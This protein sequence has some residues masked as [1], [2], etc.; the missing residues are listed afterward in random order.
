MKTATA[1]EQGYYRAMADVMN[2]ANTVDTAYLSAEQV[3]KAFHTFAD[4]A[5]PTRVKEPTYED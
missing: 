4:T 1:E 5:I 2:F 3:R